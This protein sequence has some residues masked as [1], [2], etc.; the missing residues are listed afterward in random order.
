MNFDKL[1]VELLQI[2]LKLIREKATKSPTCFDIYSVASKQVG[3]FF[4][5]F[6]VFSEKL[7]FKVDA[8][9]A[10]MT[11]LKIYLNLVIFKYPHF[12]QLNQKICVFKG[13]ILTYLC[14]LTIFQVTLAFLLAVASLCASQK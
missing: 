4:K 13:K 3:D 12:L 8:F 9:S 14:M 11:I 2:K 1:S 6:V 7:K 5:N 10:N